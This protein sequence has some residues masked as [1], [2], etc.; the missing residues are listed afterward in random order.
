MKVAGRPTGTKNSRN[1]KA[2]G[3]RKH[4]GRLSNTQKLAKDRES[5]QTRNVPIIINHFASVT[6]NNNNNAINLNN[7]S[8]VTAE[9]SHTTRDTSASATSS[10][11]RMQLEE[12]R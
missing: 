1:H 2:G 8:N 7:N 9:E 3:S 11:N 10:R 6:Q 12:K 5:G 4:S